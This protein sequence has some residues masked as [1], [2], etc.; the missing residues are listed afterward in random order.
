MA[1]TRSAR[2]PKGAL[3]CVDADILLY[4]SV[5]LFAAR[6]GLVEIKIRKCCECTM[7]AGG[8]AAMQQVHMCAAKY[9]GGPEKPH[10]I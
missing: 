10:L 7:L 9:L 4:L 1:L 8:N 3:R 6:C 5:F 2:D